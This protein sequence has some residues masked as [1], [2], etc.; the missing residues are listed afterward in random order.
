[1][2]LKKDTQEIY[3]PQ[4]VDWTDLKMKYKINSSPASVW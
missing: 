2:F 3:K 1:M 4:N